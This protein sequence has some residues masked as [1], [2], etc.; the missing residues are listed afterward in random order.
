[1]KH[2]LTLKNGVIGGYGVVFTGPDAPDLEG[3]YFT[4]DTD[5]WLEHYPAVPVIY[6]HG[7]DGEMEKRVIG[8]GRPVRQD[9][10]G[11]W[12]EAQLRQRDRYEEAVLEMVRAGKL[13]YSTGSVPHLVDQ[14]PDGRVLSWPVI[15]LTLTKTPAAGP[16]LTSVSEVR[17]HYKAV[18]GLGGNE[19][20]KKKWLAMIKRFIPAISDEDAEKVVD[21]LLLNGDAPQAPDGDLAKTLK[22]VQGLLEKPPAAESDAQDAGDG[23]PITEVQVKAWM[24][25]A[26]KP[27]VTPQSDTPPAK[28]GDG[29][30]ALKSVAVMTMGE[31]PAAVKAVV[32]DLY[33][34]DYAVKRYVQRQAFGRYLRY[35]AR[36]L[37]AAQVKSLKRIVLT[38]SQIK[39]FVL[40]GGSVAALKTDMSEAVD[41]L[42]GYLVPEDMRLQMIE[43]LPG[44]TVMRSGADVTTTSRD[45]MTKV[46]VTG[47]GDRYVNGVRMTWVG[48]TPS[49][50]DAATNPTFGVEQTP[51]HIS[52]ATVRVPR[53]L[54][55]DTPFN[56][57]GK[58]SEWVSSAAAIDEDEQFL[59]GNGIAKPEGVLP[60][61]ANPGTRIS[62]VVTGD[63]GA[64][65]Y[66]GLSRLRYAIA[67]QYRNRAVWMMN[68][69]TA[70]AIAEIFDG[71]G[72]PLL[73]PNVQEGEPD[74]MLGY[75]VM[76]SEALPDIA[77]NAY[78]VL[79]GDRMGYQVA[80][81]IGM[82]V[83]RDETTHSE[84]DIVKFVFRRRFGGQ[85][86]AEWAFAALKVAAS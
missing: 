58:I 50:G 47:G 34:E 11:V 37:D 69:N 38:P 17:S 1:M 48:D 60:G 40:S 9:E 81:R 70:S 44:M 29:D 59:I 51:I 6:E 30:A 2:K 26:L 45:V 75:A 33:G 32:G 83:I 46:K 52:M 65:T 79:F 82:S 43:R 5:L 74:R 61:G 55:E 31:T 64:I 19:T 10:F 77:A 39:S 57:S 13:G 80:D 4:A 54:L 41:T 73:Q 67:R 49:E 86:A 15:E 3:D 71:N 76:T 23:A 22:A 20:M 8:V 16:Y 18:S 24:A 53:A 72:R 84:E 28:P 27:Y 62:E 66:L 78:P 42:G 63:A 12:Y 35:G 56:L 68:D 7:F 14:A 21:L 85:L 36:A 25:E